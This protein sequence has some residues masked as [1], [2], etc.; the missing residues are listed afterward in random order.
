MILSNSLEYVWLGS[1]GR[2]MVLNYWLVSEN[3]IWLL[4][5]SDLVLAPIVG[6]FCVIQLLKMKHSYF[7]FWLNFR[8][9]VGFNFI[10]FWWHLS[11]ENS[12]K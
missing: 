3:D 9:L 1:F 6:Q 4:A 8:T 12:E 5:C 10:L 7:D 11:R 2:G